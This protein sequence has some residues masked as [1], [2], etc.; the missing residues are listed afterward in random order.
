MYTANLHLRACGPN[1]VPSVH[2]SANNIVKTTAAASPQLMI[3][4]AL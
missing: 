1:F 3:V 4:Q 2:L